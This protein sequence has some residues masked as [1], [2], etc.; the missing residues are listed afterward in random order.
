MYFRAIS[1]GSVDIRFNIRLF[2]VLTESKTLFMGNT[3]SNGVFNVR[4]IK[5][6]SSIQSRSSVWGKQ[7][8]S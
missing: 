5:N 2:Y 4:K 3:C 6:C 1:G 8:D 7:K